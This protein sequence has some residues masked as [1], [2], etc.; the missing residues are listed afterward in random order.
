MSKCDKTTW[1][2]GT[3]WPVEAMPLFMRYI[4][5]ALPQTLPIQAMR[6][7]LSR[8]WGLLHFEVAI[9]FGITIAWTSIFL[10]LGV[11]IFRHKC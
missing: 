5:Y 2:P 9:G 4:S 1:T 8:G 10:V 7:I 6:F 11:V 3:V